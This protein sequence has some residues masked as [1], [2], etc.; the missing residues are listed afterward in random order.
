MQTSS[1]GGNSV[2]M[3][4]RFWYDEADGA[5]HMTAPGVG[6]FHVA[7]NGD[8][9]SKRGHPSL[10]NVLAQCLREGRAPAPLDGNTDA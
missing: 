10:F 5:I 9:E 3:E 7:V 1:R 2:Y 6:N 8:A 4:V